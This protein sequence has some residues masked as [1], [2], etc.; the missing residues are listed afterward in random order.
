VESTVGQGSTFTVTIPHG[1]A[2]LPS[3]YIHAAHSGAAT[4]VGANV[5][6]EEALRWLGDDRS[7]ADVT[8]I[9]D[10]SPLTPSTRLE[11]IVER[12]LLVVADDNADTGT[13]A[14]K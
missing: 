11:P 5:Y 12:E 10:S 6:A 14:R 13:T 1:T 3:D 9:P 4:A 8:A 2:H 7:P